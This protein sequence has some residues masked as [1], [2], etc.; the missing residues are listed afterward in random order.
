MCCCSMR[1]ARAVC[2]IFL[3]HFCIRR[4]HTYTF[5]YP[6]L[7]ESTARPI[8][9]PCPLVNRLLSVPAMHLHQ[10]QQ[11]LLA[12][13]T[14]QSTALTVLPRRVR[15]ARTQREQCV[16][17][18]FV[19]GGASS[20]NLQTL[21][22]LVSAVS[23]AIGAWW[24]S[25]ELL[26]EEVSDEHQTGQKLLLRHGTAL[27]ILLRILLALQ[28]SARYWKVELFLPCMSLIIVHTGDSWWREYP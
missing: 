14:R 21:S 19:V 26:R 8:Y 2:L 27:P 10:L 28:C 4:V 25:S 23:F 16:A 3:T 7:Q 1:L 20:S 11:R 18:A 13:P 6:H 12:T 15:R 22:Q 9:G 5:T 24:L 17:G